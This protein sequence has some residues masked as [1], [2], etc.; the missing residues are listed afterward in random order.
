MTI[1]EPLGDQRSQPRG[2]TA[3]AVKIPEDG[4]AD[5]VFLLEPEQLRVQRLRDVAGAAAGIHRIRGAIHG[6]PELF[7]EMI[8][9][10]LAAHRTCAG[11]REI[12]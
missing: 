8:P 6:G 7:H 4:L 1:D 3:A 2:E 9:R 10:V 12:R 5:A 11:E